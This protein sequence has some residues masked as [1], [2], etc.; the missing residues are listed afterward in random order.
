MIEFKGPEASVTCSRIAEPGDVLGAVLFFVSP[1]PDSIAGQTLF[2]D[3][4]ITAAQ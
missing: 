1:A 4:G 2:P 3:G